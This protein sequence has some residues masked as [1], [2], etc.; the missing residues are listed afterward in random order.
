MLTLLVYVFR[1]EN[2]L[3]QNLDRSG[4]RIDF[5]EK[6]TP[7]PFVASRAADLIHLEQQC[8]RVAV[9]TNL[10]DLLDVAAFLAFPPKFLAAP[11]VITGFSRSQRFRIGFPIHVRQ[12][13]HIAGFGILRNGWY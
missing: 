4:G 10:F 12:H 9:Q 5:S 6:T 7:I 13:Q 1:I 11:A 8:I 3:T 2:S